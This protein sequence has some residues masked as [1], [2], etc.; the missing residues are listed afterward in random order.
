MS[1]A[2][3]TLPLVLALAGGLACA[4]KGAHD[5]GE[6]EHEHGA[7]AGPL[8][9]SDVRGLKLMTV[10]EARE[11]GRWMPGEAAGD[12]AAQA[13]LSSPVKGLVRQLLAVPGQALRAGQYEDGL[14]EV[15][16]EVSALLVAHFPANG[17]A[18]G[19]NEL[20]DAPV[21]L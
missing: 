14:T 20:P 13:L 2:L 10:P 6:A 15:L 18:P 1:R 19:S 21:L 5:H 9:L 11:E 4:R 8:K 7:E 16:A 12:E 3:I 17:H